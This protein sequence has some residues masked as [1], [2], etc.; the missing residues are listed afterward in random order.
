MKHLLDL[1]DELEQ[2]AEPL[3]LYFDGFEST[4]VQL[5]ALEKGHYSLS[6]DRSYLVVCEVGQKSKLAVMYLQADGF[7]AE[8]LEGGILDLRKATEQEFILPYSD[9]L[10]DSLSRHPKVRFV[11]R[12]G[13]Q[14]VVRGSLSVEEVEAF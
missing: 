9:A 3:A 11:A 4:A 8:H 14:L 10:L 13:E 6:K 7:A 1:R 5:Q 2:E 12:D